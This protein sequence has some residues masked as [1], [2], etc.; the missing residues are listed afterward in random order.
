MHLP[1]DNSLVKA[2]NLQDFIEQVKEDFNVSIEVFIRTVASYELPV[3]TDDL[4]F[5]CEFKNGDFSN[6]VLSD[7]DF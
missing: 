5:R 6:Y 3:S 4:M 1:F 2:E 7:N